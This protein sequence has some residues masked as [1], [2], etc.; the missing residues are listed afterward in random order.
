MSIKKEIF[1]NIKSKKILFLS[2][3]TMCQ[4]LP[5]FVIIHIKMYDK[6]YLKNKLYNAYLFNIY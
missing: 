4:Q 5:L 2:K 6:K 1:K 3:I